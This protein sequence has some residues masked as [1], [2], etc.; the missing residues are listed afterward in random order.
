MSKV[1]SKEYFKS[2]DYSTA[3]AYNNEASSVLAE[4]NGKLGADQLPYETVEKGNMVSNTRISV[5]SKPDGSAQDGVGIIMPTQSIYYVASDLATFTWN[6]RAPSGAPAVSVLGPPLGTALSSQPSWSTGISSLSSL[7]SKGTFLSFT[8]KEGMIR[9]IA[10]VD[11]E[12]YFVSQEA[13]GFTGNY[14]AGWR[15]WIYVFVN[16]EMVASTGPQPAGRRRTVQLPFSLP[17][18]SSDSIQVDVRWSATFDGAGTAPND[19][20]LVDEAAIRFYNCQL[21]VRN[22]YR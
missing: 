18:S 2:R 13:T 1:Y 5:D 14:G 6:R 11:I 4:L 9:G 3:D 12:Y 22:Q 7:V 16:D 19:I 10:N 8:S 17:V 15:W 20:S 21:F